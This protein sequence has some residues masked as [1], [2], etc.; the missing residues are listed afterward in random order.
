M[1]NWR[2]KIGKKQEQGEIEWR[3]LLHQ[4]FF[5]FMNEVHTLAKIYNWNL[6]GGGVNNYAVTLSQNK[7]NGI[8]CSIKM[9]ASDS[10]KYY[11]CLTKEINP[12]NINNSEY[13]KFIGENMDEALKYLH[14][15]LL[16]NDYEVDSKSEKF[17]FM[18]GAYDRYYLAKKWESERLLEEK[19]K[20]VV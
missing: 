14:T 20:E 2:N 6:W 18:G 3:F 10:Y 17:T 15:F 1:A 4:E 16:N 19:V 13:T 12:N 9:L 8:R 11:F 7:P 5:E